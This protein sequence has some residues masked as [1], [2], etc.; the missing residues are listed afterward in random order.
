MRVDITSRLGTIAQ[1]SG[2]PFVWDLRCFEKS[3]TNAKA[4]RRTG[5]L[6]LFHPSVEL[7]DEEGNGSGGPQH[8]SKTNQ[9]ATW[10]SILV[11]EHKRGADR[12]KPGGESS[13]KNGECFDRLTFICLALQA[14]RAYFLL[15][16]NLHDLHD[17]SHSMAYCYPAPFPAMSVAKVRRKFLSTT[18]ACSD[19][20]D[21]VTGGVL[22][23]AATIPAITGVH[24]SPGT[25][26]PLC[27]S[28][29]KIC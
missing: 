12:S 29:R 10:I 2:P 14:G 6:L 24:S 17:S 21:Y 18:I 13:S 3:E 4:A 22:F 8:Q 26:T 20:V 9:Q 16:L 25:R 19:K 27:W 1:L 23:T 11:C 28:D 7:H 15:V 5:K